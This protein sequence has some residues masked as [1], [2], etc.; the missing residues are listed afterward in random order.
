MKNRMYLSLATVIAALCTFAPLMAT[1]V[2]AQAKPDKFH[3]VRRRS[4]P[5]GTLFFSYHWE[6]STGNL[7][8]LTGCQVGENVAYP[9]KNNPYIWSSPPY[10]ANGGTRNP[11]EIWLPA[12]LGTFN[13]EHSNPFGFL[14]PYKADNFIATQDYRWRCVK[15]NGNKPTDF[16]GYTGIQIERTVA[17]AGKPTDALNCW[18]YTITKSGLKAEVKPL[19]EGGACPKAKPGDEEESMWTAGNTGLEGPEAAQSGVSFSLTSSSASLHEPILLQFE[20]HNYLTDPV[21]F[22]LGLNKN[23]N[24]EVAVTNPSNV[25]VT[26]RLSSGGFGESGEVSLGAGEVFSRSL[27]LNQ[28][29]DFAAPGDYKVTITLLGTIASESGEVLAYRPSQEF[30]F[31]IDPSD[32]ARLAQICSDLADAAIAAPTIAERMDAARTLSYVN[33]P[34]AVPALSR[35]LNQGTFVE[36]YAVEGLGRIASPEAISA[37]WGAAGHPDPDVRSLS[38]FTLNQIDMQSQQSPKDAD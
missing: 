27:L 21:T 29:N 20:V 37:L 19:P 34:L 4:Q 6:S 26:Q 12:T 13:D 9:G 7:D 15:V 33:D 2:G 23:A 31:H 36:Q 14:K 10:G 5:D 28:W 38:W 18:F 30:Y 16:A 35:V 24:F 8:D 32:P 11:T 3:E 17:L 25:T 22:D 1:P